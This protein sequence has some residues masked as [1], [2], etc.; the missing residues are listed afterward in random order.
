[1]GA[2]DYL[3]KPFNPTLLRARVGASL[4]K[5]RFREQ[6]QAYREQALKDQATLE[7]HRSLAQMVA[8]V[9]HEINTPLGI[10]STA[11]RLSSPPIVELFK[12]DSEHTEILNDVS[13]ATSL[14]KK[15]ITRA[16]GWSRI[17]KEFP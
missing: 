2:E 10:A 17:L 13:K 8:G 3:P 14:L 9:A 7:R 1:L 16:I 12:K 5:K 6:E 15:N 4:E 11:K